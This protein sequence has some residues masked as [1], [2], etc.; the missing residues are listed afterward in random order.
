MRQG[1][2]IAVDPSLAYWAVTVGSTALLLALLLWAKPPWQFLLLMTI[3]LLVVENTLVDPLLAL[4]PDSD[5]RILYH[6][7]ATLRDQFPY[8]VLRSVTL[9]AVIGTVVALTNKSYKAHRRET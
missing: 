5:S 8:W 2:C 3:V 6:P 7:S 1:G 4:P 9:V